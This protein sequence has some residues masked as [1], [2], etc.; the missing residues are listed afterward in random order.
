MRSTHG[1]EVWLVVDLS[2]VFE[3]RV[4]SAVREYGL[5]EVNNGHAACSEGLGL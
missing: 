2:L 1:R 3:A 4:R 5:K